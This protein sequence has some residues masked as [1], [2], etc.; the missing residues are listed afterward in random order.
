MLTDEQ[1]S[2]FGKRFSSMLVDLLSINQDPDL[3]ALCARIEAIRLELKS[4][5]SQIA[6]TPGPEGPQGEQG[7]PG[8]DAGPG[9]DGAQGPAGAEGPAGPQGADG[10]PGLDGPAGPQGAEGPQGPAGLDGVPGAEGPAG[11]QGPAGLDGVPGAEGPAGPQGEEAPKSDEVVSDVMSVMESA[12]S[13]L[14]SLAS[15]L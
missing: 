8:L 11:P 2:D 12:L 9:A 15:L 10:A 6:L 1:K 3:C 4:D 5:V 13:E 14:R 7:P